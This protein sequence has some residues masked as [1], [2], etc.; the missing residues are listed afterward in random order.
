[1]PTNVSDAAAQD[2]TQYLRSVLSEEVKFRRDR[3]QQIFSWASS[4]LVAI[5][6]GSTALAW[7]KLT[8][9]QH[10]LALIQSIGLYI[11]ILF[12]GLFSAYWINYHYK[13]EKL[14]RD[15]SKKYDKKLGLPVSLDD[16]RKHDVANI[17][18]LLG[19]MVV[20]LASAVLHFSF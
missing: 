12:L 16:A 9:Q 18:A 13:K 15:E 5:I 8:P 10:Q 1:M 17:L 3:R 7:T 2:A 6:G 4:L 20:A 11:A 19:L 14:F